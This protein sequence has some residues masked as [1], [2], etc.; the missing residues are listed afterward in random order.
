MPRKK[1]EAVQVKLRLPR[2]IHRKLELAMRRAGA[3]STMN[4]EIVSRLESSFASAERDQTVKDAA[5]A[6]V[7]R[8]LTEIPLSELSGWA[9]DAVQSAAAADHSQDP[10]TAAAM[11][12]IKDAFE[13]VRSPAD[14]ASGKFRQGGKS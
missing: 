11:D 5:R 14:T 4:A 8:V 10:K 13:S 2:E 9:R 6:A 12:R 3:A 7:H 1:S